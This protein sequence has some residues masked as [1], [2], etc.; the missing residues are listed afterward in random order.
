M[1]KHRGA[2]AQAVVDELVGVVKA[3]SLDPSEKDSMCG[4]LSWIRRESIGQAI[5]ALAATVGDRHYMGEPAQKFLARC[6]ELRSQLVHGHALPNF[7]EVNHRGAQLERLVGDLIAVSIVHQTGIVPEATWVGAHPASHWDG[8]TNSVPLEGDAVV[9][10]LS[11]ADPAQPKQA[12]PGP[13][14]ND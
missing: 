11:P 9:W 10:P 14:S 2:P 8:N 12:P 13:P 6:Y 4:A 5:R 7:D 3:S 1:S